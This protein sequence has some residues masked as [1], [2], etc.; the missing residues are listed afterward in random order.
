NT[1]SQ[2]SPSGEVTTL[3]TGLNGPSGIVVN[4]EDEVL[5]SEF[6]ANFSGTG[7][8]VQ[9]VSRDGTTDPFITGGGLRDPV[10]IAV[11][12]DDVVYVTN[13]STGE[14][15]RSDGETITPFAEIGGTV[16]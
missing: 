10:G 11:G 1:V 2:I 8:T 7:A 16:N 6:G 3:A 4:S 12:E 5:V 15:F 9:V 14:I 13:W